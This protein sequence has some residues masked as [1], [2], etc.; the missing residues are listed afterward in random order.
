MNKRVVAFFLVLVMIFT[1]VGCQP[2]AT[3]PTATD[4]KAPATEE[5]ADEKQEETT[6]EPAASGSGELDFLSIATGGTGGTYYPLGG[7]IATILNSP[8][9]G[10]NLQA[11]AQATGASVENVELITRGDAEVAFVQNDVTYYAFNGVEAFAEKGKFE[12]IR[13]LATLYPEVVQIIARADAE[14]TSVED[15]AGKRVAVGAPGS[16]TEVNA[17]QILEIH[18]LSYEDLAK[19]DY[20]SFAEATDQL[21]NNQI[22]V[23]FVTAAVPTSAV[24]E[25][26]TTADVALIPITAE[27]IKELSEKY[28]Y[29]IQVDI[30]PGDY[31]GQEEV[32]SAA[33]VMAMLIVSE[34]MDEGLVYNITKAIFEN[35]QTIAESHARGSDITLESALDGMPIEVHPGAQ[36]YYDEK[37]VQAN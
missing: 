30:Q 35:T 8:D 27:K 34:D 21:K 22:D 29:Y 33:A 6:T 15:M 18:G 17:R 10:L 9:N 16:G 31:R 20:L 37:G 1:F 13:G 32:V 14:L 12:N 4:E 25:V 3:E 24:T 28:P 36:K 2:Q 23:A 7:A 5:K 11:T 19:V 26:S